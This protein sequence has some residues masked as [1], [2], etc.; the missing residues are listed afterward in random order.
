MNTGITKGREDTIRSTDNL[1]K[2]NSNTWIL[3]PMN[4][5]NQKDHE[6][7]NTMQNIQ[8]LIYKDIEKTKEK[9]HEH[10]FKSTK[11]HKDTQT[12]TSDGDNRLIIK[13][14]GVAKTFNYIATCFIESVYYFIYEKGLLI[15]YNGEDDV[16]LYEF[17]EI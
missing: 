1:I 15:M 4:V 14:C 13:S 11:I 17:D 7:L 5:L 16:K 8:W 3:D 12:I 2:C 10:A 9:L 6:I